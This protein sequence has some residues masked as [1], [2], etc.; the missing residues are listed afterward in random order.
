LYS[1]KQANKI[2]I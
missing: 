1:A 2:Y